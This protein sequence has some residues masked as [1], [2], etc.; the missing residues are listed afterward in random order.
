MPKLLALD[1][2]TSTTKVS[3]WIDGRLTHYQTEKPRQAAQQLL[4]FVQRALDEAALTVSQL[5][6]IVTTTGPGSFTGLRIG[7]GAAQGLSMANQTPLIGISCLELLAYSASKKLT[8][9][10]F[11]VCLPAREQEVYFAAYNREED[12]VVLQGR[13]CVLELN[14]ENENLPT[15]TPKERVG[16]GAVCQHREQLETL[17][18]ITLKD[19]LEGLEVAMEDLCGSALQKLEKGEILVAETLLPNYVK[20]QLDYH[21]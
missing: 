3:L 5:D 8:E 4:P 1:S 11:L 16:V 6:A 20:E 21:S 10:Y 2:S 15:F 12:N 7:I 19:C 14:A 18:D 9:D 13:E 17:L